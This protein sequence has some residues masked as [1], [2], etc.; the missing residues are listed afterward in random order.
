MQAVVNEAITRQQEG[1]LDTPAELVAFL[2]DQLYRNPLGVLEL[3]WTKAHRAWYGT[4]AQ[5]RE[6]WIALFVQT[7]YLLLSLWGGWLLWRCRGTQREW[8]VLVA[9]VVLYFWG[10]TVLVLSIV[11]YMIPAMGLLFPSIA[12]ALEK[13]LT[14]FNKTALSFLSCDGSNSH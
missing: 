11:R 10:M 3:V 14:R 12:L 5:H 1:K 6:E 9:A 13:A 8:L 7:V 4:D 2:G